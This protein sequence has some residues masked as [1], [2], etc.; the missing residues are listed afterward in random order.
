MKIFHVL[1]WQVACLETALSWPSA[2]APL[3]EYIFVSQ[4]GQGTVSVTEVNA[5]T[6]KVTSPTR[7]VLS[8][9]LTEPC[10][11]AVDH[12][13]QRLYI[14]DPKRHKVF[15]YKMYFGDHG[16]SVR[17]DEQYTVVYDVTPRWIAVD[18]QG[19]LFATDE[20]RSFIAEV[21]ATELAKLGE[22]KKGED[23]VQ[24]Q[25]H[26]LYA[27]DQNNQVDRPGGIAVDGNNIYWGNRAPGKQFGSLMSAPENPEARLAKGVPDM[28]QSLSKNVDK[29]YGVCASPN[30]VF[31]TG[32]SRTVYG[33]KPGAFNPR[34]STTVLLDD[35]AAPRGCVWDGDGTVYLADKG[36]DA[37]WSFPSALHSLGLVQASKLFDVTDPYGVA[38][39][40]PSLTLNSVGFLRGGTAQAGPALAVMLVMML[41]TL[42]YNA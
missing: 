38:V 8:K 31:Y 34:A 40:R 25:F 6:R 29:V 7:P 36:G 18:S 2:L 20:G 37:I 39:F 13:R 14:A 12:T 9:G 30:L 5:L 23:E 32:G 21:S 24:L 16:M 3:T 27:H 22:Q 11:L 1:L 42:R 4:P 15:M 19:T 41:A 33:A 35:Y 10:G 28:I 17:E 26:K